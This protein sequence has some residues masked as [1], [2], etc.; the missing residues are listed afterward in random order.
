MPATPSNSATKNTNTKA[1]V[2]ACVI[3]LFFYLVWG[4]TVWFIDY[5]THLV[6]T[7][8][9]GF[10]ITLLIGWVSFW[11]MTRGNK[12][13]TT[14]ETD[15]LIIKRHTKL[16]AMHFLRMLKLQKQKK[17]FASR[18][19]QPIYLLLSDDPSKDKSVI[20]QMGYEAYKVDEFGNDIDFP[21]LF[22]V[23]EHSILIYVSLG[24][25]QHSEYIKTL[26]TC[27]NKW[28]PRQAINGVLL[29]TD[30]ATLLKSEEQISQY[31]DSLKA[32]IKTYNR[33]FGLNLPVYN[34]ITNMGN[35][36]DFCQFFSAFDEN[37]RDDVFGATAP[38]QRHGGIDAN[39]YNQEFDHLISQLIASMSTAL[40]GQLN[41][42]YRNSIASAP[43]QF[44]LL[45]QN[46][47]LL[48]RR[49]Y[50]GDQLTDGLMF[51]GFYFTHDAQA[52][53]QNDLLA[54]V[55]NYELGNESY[56]QATQIPVQ[57][58]LFAQHIMTHVILSEHELVGIN[59]R[60]ES[61]LWLSQIAYTSSWVLILGLVMAVIKF[62]FDYQSNREA[63][64][65]RMLENYKEAIS[66]SPY[67]IENMVDN[68]PNL[69]SI[70]AIYS[71]YTQPEPWFSL[72]FLPDSSI[73]LDVEKAYRQELQQ[74]LIPSLENTIEKDLF[75]HV[76]LEE[77]A[78]TLSLLNNYRL[79]F[80][81]QRSNSQQLKSYFVETL[82][83]QGEADNTNI[84]QLGALLDDVFAQELAP[85]KVN[86][87]LESLAKKVIS[88]TG[89][90][91]LLYEHIK[92]SATF[93]KRIDVRNDLGSNFTKLFA[94]SPQYVGYLVPYIYTP[95]GFNELDL[96]VNSPLIEQALQ[97]YQG[98]TDS[99]PS[100]SEMYRISRDL[101][102]SYQND[103]IN[104]WRDFISHVSI[105][106]VSSSAELDST[107][108]TLS[109]AS[110][111]PLAA[112]Y[113][114]ITKYSTV[115]IQ[116]QEATSSPK[117]DANSQEVAPQDVDKKES[118]V[119][120]TQNFLSYHQQ[121]SVNQQNQKPLDELLATVAQTK[122]WLDQ[123]FQAK[124]PE[125]LAYQ[126]LTNSVKQDDPISSLAALA[127]QQQPLIKQLVTDISTQSNDIVLF[128]AHEYLN[129]SWQSDVYQPYQST[130]A[131]FYP[132]KAAA[133]SDASVADVTAFFK[134]GGMIDNFYNTKLS[135]FI[136]DGSEHPYL[137]GL[138][139]N[140][141]LALAP[142]L[143][144]AID[145]AKKIKQALFLNDPNKA[146]ISFQLEVVAMSSNLTQFTISTTKPIYSYQHGPVLWSEQVWQGAA[147]LTDTL[148]VN[149][150][151]PT[152]A[153]N[154]ASY[155][156]DWNW[157]KLIE[158][159]LT[160]TSE[161][162][163]TIQ[164]SYGDDSVQ[165]GIKTQGQ[166]NPF[167]PAFFTGFVLPNDI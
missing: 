165:L 144:D 101:K 73:K 97:T 18:Y 156:G 106:S 103:Y 3:G 15:S 160:S 145:R 78:K 40:A 107:L 87:D 141:G 113:Q 7:L 41:Q 53:Q 86:N 95:A 20:T 98:V 139:P 30:V 75:V 69:Y 47:W 67:D 14:N 102:K 25:D 137:D 112:F 37:K 62:D 134:E 116:A 65:D 59:K 16:I 94:F 118:A 110:A 84:A 151:S 157:F 24:D 17:H 5:R 58:T 2:W 99:T 133:G 159:N 148:N 150:V 143:W 61:L 19:D 146:Q 1:I 126:T 71:L 89:V 121:V 154:K 4:G 66:A 9:I 109:S 105:N 8:A 6:A 79:L 35:I 167:E 125:L 11:L 135:R 132:F 111:N 39:W 81:K 50:R 155:Q 55:I 57:Q 90:E 124:D 45:K 93:S 142:E 147:T 28:R 115:E 44:G 163:T 91:T 23:S 108:K 83:E 138:I 36:S 166:V 88:Q 130:L 10:I 123:Y 52:H 114:T 72:S 140:T 127:N 63:Q 54:G 161:Q 32:D 149:A 136:T 46:M 33:A 120:I 131:S 104:Y 158:P 117:S 26:C 42:D 77:Q 64:A 48:L 43:Y 70:R 152:V 92:N 56:L 13:S 119:Q 80:Y 29:T 82:N 68:I 34:L 49:L 21:I 100:A 27:L 51:R 74:V 128:L 153:T 85:V 60:K 162:N 129:K 38:Y 164:F 76:S 96:S 122:T 31:A 22:W 12:N